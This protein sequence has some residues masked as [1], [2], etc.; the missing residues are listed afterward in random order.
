[1][2][3]SLAKHRSPKDDGIVPLKRS[4]KPLNRSTMGNDLI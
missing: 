3:E 4:R 2:E 1:M